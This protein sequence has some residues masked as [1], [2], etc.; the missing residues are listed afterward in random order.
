[1]ISPTG[2]S[3]LLR[4]PTTPYPNRPAYYLCDRLLWLYRCTSVLL[5]LCFY[6]LLFSLFLLYE[7]LHTEIIT[8]LR[9]IGRHYLL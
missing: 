2:I 9:S 3:V 8:L 4:H 6:L 1:M 5:T 7:I